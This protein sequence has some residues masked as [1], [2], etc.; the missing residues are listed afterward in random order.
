MIDLRDAIVEALGPEKAFGED[1]DDEAGDGCRCP[2]GSFAGEGARRTR[3][4]EPAYDDT[5]PL[6]VASSGVPMPENPR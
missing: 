2:A 5:K 1:E 6:R 3:E 4:F